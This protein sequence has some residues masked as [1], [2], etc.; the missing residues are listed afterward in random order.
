M[1]IAPLLIPTGLLGG[2]VVN[3]Y[4]GRHARNNG[5]LADEIECDLREPGKFSRSKSKRSPERLPFWRALG[6]LYERAFTQPQTVNGNWVVE[7]AL[8]SR[9]LPHLEGGIGRLPGVA[10]CA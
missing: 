5:M 2:E 1:K 8:C 6:G 3:S 4:A 10:W 7:C 9:C